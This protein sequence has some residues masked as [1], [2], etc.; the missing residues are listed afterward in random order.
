VK[1]I[2]SNPNPDEGE[3]R[4]NSS[5]PTTGISSKYGQPHPLVIDRSVWRDFALSEPDEKETNRS[6]SEGPEE[7]LN[8]LG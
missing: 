5:Y 2:W 4:G 6:R 7:L 1:D 3:K 8:I